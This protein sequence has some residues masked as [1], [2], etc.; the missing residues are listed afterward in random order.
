M[1]NKKRFILNGEKVV[2]ITVMLH[3]IIDSTIPKGECSHRYAV[4]T[5]VWGDEDQLYCTKREVVT[6]TPSSYYEK[7]LQ[8]IEGY[9]SRCMMKYDP[10]EGDG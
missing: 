3:E 5:R 9:I 7:E 10:L 2:H 1:K 8:R 4:K 6:K